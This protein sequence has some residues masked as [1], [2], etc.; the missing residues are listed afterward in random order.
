MLVHSSLGKWDFILGIWYIFIFLLPLAL[1]CPSLLGHALPSTYTNPLFFRYRRR[2]HKEM[3]EQEK[4]EKHLVD[5]E[6]T[7]S[8]VVR[9]TNVNSYSAS[10]NN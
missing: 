1:H 9:T 4:Y 10:H 6:S 7:T 8:D 5:T 3:M 2:K